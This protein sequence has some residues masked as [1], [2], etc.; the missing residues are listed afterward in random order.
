MT[1]EYFDYKNKRFYLCYYTAMSQISA[2]RPQPS[3]FRYVV[4]TLIC[5]SALPLLALPDYKHVGWFLLAAAAIALLR[6]RRAS[7]GRDMYVLI[8]ALAA[9]GLVPINTDISW[10]HML[11]MGAIMT[12]VIAGPFLV[13]R[14]IFHDKHIVFPFRFGRKWRKREIAY[15]LLAAVVSYFL[16]PF[17][18]A[19]GSY[20]NW[21]VTLDTSHVIRLFV[22]TN[23]LG[24]W[25]ELFFIGT[26]L[27]LLRAHVPFW[28]ANLAQA[29]LFT[30]FLYELG[31]RGWGPFAIFV[32]ALTQGYIFNQSKS[33]LYIVTIHLTIDFVLFLTLIHLHHP[34]YLRVFITSPF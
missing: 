34:E 5:M 18:L 29:T 33:L 20:L 23:G 13:T 24:I 8:G 17:Y 7:F 22:G 31:F 21:G 14:H 25:D 15:V 16:L 9:L 3:G 2:A 27:A 1:I 28:A 26:A 30:T 4:V 6:E 19:Q 10:G 11:F 32:F 12:L